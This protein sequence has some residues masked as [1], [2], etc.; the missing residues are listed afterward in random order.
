MVRV[1]DGFAGQSRMPQRL[2]ATEPGSSLTIIAT[3]L[4]PGIWYFSKTQR[5]FADVIHRQLLEL[6]AQQR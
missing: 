3:L 4:V 6:A 1:S 2:S 5:A